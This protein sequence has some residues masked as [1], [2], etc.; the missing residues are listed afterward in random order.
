LRE[1]LPQELLQRCPGLLLLLLSLLLETREALLLHA[2]LWDDLRKALCWKA[3]CWNDLC[4]KDLC[5]KDILLLRPSLLEGLLLLLPLLRKLL[6]PLLRKLLL[7]RQVLLK[8]LLQRPRQL[9]IWI[10]LA[11]AQACQAGPDPHH[12]HHVRL[13]QSQTSEEGPVVLE[14]IRRR[15]MSIMCAQ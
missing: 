2:L 15:I 5:W 4:W 11:H 7:P 13:A 8:S 9:G 1:G 10:R 12:H 6:L 14:Q 3:L